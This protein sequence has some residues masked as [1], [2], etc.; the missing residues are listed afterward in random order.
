M[1]SRRASVEGPEISF[2]VHYLNK[3]FSRKKPCLRAHP[4]PKHV[5]VKT[6]SRKDP[7]KFRKL[8]ETY[9]RHSVAAGKNLRKLR[10]MIIAQDPGSIIF[11]FGDHGLYLATGESFRADRVFY[12]QDSFGVLGGIY[13]ADTCSEYFDRALADKGYMTTTW[14]ARLLVQCLAGGDDPMPVAYVHKLL[15]HNGSTLDPKEFVY[16]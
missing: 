8:Q 10:D 2:L 1:F 16:E 5:N 9:H 15:Q 13:P 7:H 11:V 3:T 12:V 6:F 4:S 14:V